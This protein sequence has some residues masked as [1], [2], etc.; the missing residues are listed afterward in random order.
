MIRLSR[1]NCIALLLLLALG[2]A[3]LTLHVTTHI[4]VDQA[5]C[6][7]CAGHVNPAHAIPTA[8]HELPRPVAEV[9]RFFSTAPISAAVHISHYRGR[10]PPVIV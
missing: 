7:Y 9:T 10:A 5:K 4:P 1:Q 3:A 6:Q 8:A 2:H